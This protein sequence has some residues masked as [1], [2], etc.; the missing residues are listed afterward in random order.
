M[1]VANIVKKLIKGLFTKK[2]KEQ[3]EGVKIVNGKIVGYDYS[4]KEKQEEVKEEIIV[5]NEVS[6]E[7]IKLD[8]PLKVDTQEEKLEEVREVFQEEQEEELE[9]IQ[10]M[11]ALPKSK[12]R[13][14]KI[15]GFYLTLKAAGRSKNTIQGYKYDLNFWQ[16]VAKQ[17]KQT[18]YNLKLKDI[19][20]ANAGQD[21]NTV[22]RR[23]SALKQLAKWYL[24]DNFPLLHIECAKV[25]IGKGK[26][27]IPKAK[28]E[29][30]FRQIR[31]HA[32]EL[33]QD[34]QREG[35]WLALMLMCGL[36]ISEIQTV[37]PG[38]DFITVIG[39]G[40]KERKIPCP[41]WLLKALNS[42]KSKGNGGYQKKRQIVDRKLRELGYTHFHSLRHTFA[43]TLLHRGVEL[44][45]IQ[46]LLGHSSI[47]TTQ[48]YAK[49][50][51]DKEVLNVLEN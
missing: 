25:M 26:A 10:G 43:T 19:E 20:E 44:E 21:I 12:G 30:E 22:K 14:R 45:K 27:R 7:S 35:I 24:R 28:S 51:I 49:T 42:Q 50:K 39:K 34:N 4:K 18:I 31:D 2:E 5:Q 29:E 16:K 15:D 37:V 41:D 32:K 11:E 40:D 23:M 1:E 38:K 17:K 6:N 48:I 33:I 13:T 46:T 36:R 9:E 3:N 8:D 47:A